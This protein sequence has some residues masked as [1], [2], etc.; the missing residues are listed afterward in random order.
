MRSVR[1]AA[2]AVFALVGLSACATRV[3]TLEYEIL[4]TFPHDAGAYTQGL[5]F[6]D[7]YLFESTGQYGSSSLRKVDIESGRVVARTA[8]DSTLFAEGLALVD[9]ELY[10][11]TWKDGLV[12]VY[13][14]ETLERTREY[15][16][17]GEGWGLCYD[18]ASLYMS[19]GTST[20][21]R[22]DPSTFE[23][24]EEVSVTA[25]GRAVPRLN[26]LECLDDEIYAN[27]YQTD[28]IVRIDKATGDVTGEIDGSGLSL[29]GGR[30]GGVDAVLNGIA[31]IPETG[32]LLLT[33]KL[34]S[35]VLAVRLADADE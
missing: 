32:V 16:Y 12:L 6:H 5:L 15:E 28:R 10:Q 4:T 19:N 9:A 35:R 21:T 30:P 20:L 29:M 23:V 26:E 25:G 18:G 34:W 11:L 3:P 14:L 2:C 7:G 24:L 17:E 1:P 13:D 22:R 31:Y 33:G 8:V 27:V